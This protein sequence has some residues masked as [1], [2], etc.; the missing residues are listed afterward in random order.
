VIDG[1]K[2]E[3]KGSRQMPAKSDGVQWI[4][5]LWPFSHPIAARRG[6]LEGT[7]TASQGPKS[8]TLCPPLP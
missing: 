7:S 2:E 5:S 4:L 1:K 6:R 3:H 8:K